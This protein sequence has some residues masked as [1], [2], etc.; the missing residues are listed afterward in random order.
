MSRED[1]L[2]GKE[3]DDMKRLAGVKRED[4]PQITQNDLPKA[5]SIMKDNDIKFD[6]VKSPLSTLKPYQKDYQK[7]KVKSIYK[8][9]TTIEDIKPI[10]I[11]NDNYIVDGHH[12]FLAALLKFGKKSSIKAIKLNY[13]SDDAVKIYSKLEGKV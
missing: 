9:L 13:P 1:N 4:M 3:L 8:D 10:I 12:R 5:I 6:V 11:S 2:I 7:D